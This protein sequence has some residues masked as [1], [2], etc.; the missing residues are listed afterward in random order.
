MWKGIVER[1]RA[2]HQLKIDY[3]DTKMTEF[4]GRVSSVGH[5]SSLIHTTQLFPHI[6]KD[7]YKPSLFSRICQIS[8]KIIHF[9][10]M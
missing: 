2:I 10:A 5:S 1:T 9:L 4:L 3:Y 8:T 6:A 7:F